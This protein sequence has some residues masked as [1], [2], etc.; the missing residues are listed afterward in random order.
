M[1]RHGPCGEIAAA[2]AWNPA[3]ITTAAKYP[4]IVSDHI[5]AMPGNIHAMEN[6]KP[7]AARVRAATCSPS[8]ISKMAMPTNASGHRPQGG[9]DTATAT[10]AT[11]AIAAEADKRGKRIDISERP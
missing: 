1:T 10:P 7:R 5:Q 2:S 8:D 11:T 4:G 3:K 9:N 6:K